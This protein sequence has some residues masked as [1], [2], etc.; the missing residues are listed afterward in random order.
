[1]PTDSRRP[2]F[3]D[4]HAGGR[5]L[6]LPNAWDVASAVAFVDAGFPAV[7]TTSFG[8]GAAAGRPDGGRAS[9]DA[10]AAL[11]RALAPLDAHVSA[12]VEDGYS[13]DPDEVAAYVAGLGCAGVNV[14]DGTDGRLVDP[15]V[16]AAKI[17]AITGRCPGL[18]VNARVDNYWLGADA[19]V[20]AV[21]RRAEAY[22]AAGA[23][24]I[25]VPG[26]TDPDELREL[27]AAIPVPVNV[28]AVPGRML[29]ELG[30]LGIRR[31]STGSL[32]YRAALDAAVGVATAIRG[33]GTPMS[34]TP[35]R[36]A[37]QAIVR[38][39]RRT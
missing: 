13:D 1:M 37:Q 35:Y 11:V 4:L 19:T 24:G 26:A 12:D 2:G 8:V 6:L 3:H 7:G 22:V 30:G 17:A 38:F 28:L 25:F 10:T 16:H 14:E 5:P 9:R 33:G 36:D 34:A 27:A 32:P 31:V 21:L 15:E 23:D 39:A 20:G 18:F 29:D